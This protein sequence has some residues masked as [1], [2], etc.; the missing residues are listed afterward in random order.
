MIRY[1]K[2]IFAIILSLALVLFIL[3]IL[4]INYFRNDLILLINNRIN[5]NGPFCVYYS[6]IELEPWRF[7]PNITF[8]VSKPNITLNSN[9][10]PVSI[11]RASNLYLNINLLEAIRKNFVVNSLSIADG[12]INAD[13]LLFNLFTNTKNNDAGDLNLYL[14]FKNIAL[15]NVVLSYSVSSN[16]YYKIFISSAQIAGKYYNNTGFF[17]I[18]TVSDSIAYNEKIIKVLTTKVKLR[19]DLSINRN[20]IVL[21]NSEL[22]LYNINFKTDFSYGFLS[23]SLKI[24]LMAQKINLGKQ[25][26]LLHKFTNLKN[27]KGHLSLD[28]LYLTNMSI[29]DY[30]Y[31]QSNFALYNSTFQYNNI[32]HVIINELSGSFYFNSSLKDTKLYINHFKIAHQG[33]YINGAVKIA[34]LNQPLVFLDSKFAIDKRSLT[35]LQKNFSADFSGTL[36]T[37]IKLS[38]LSDFNSAK[39]LQIKSSLL[40]EN[41]TYKNF[42]FLTGFKTQIEIN[43]DACNARFSGLLN[44]SLIKGDIHIPLFMQFLNTRK[45]LFANVSI[46]SDNVDLNYLKNVFGSTSGPKKGLD[47]ELGLNVKCNFNNVEYGNYQFNKVS[48]NLNYGRDVVD[49]PDFN[50]SAF[51]GS[52]KGNASFNNNLIFVSDFDNINIKSLSTFLSNEFKQTDF[53]NFIDGRLAG[54]IRFSGNIDSLLLNKY[55]ETSVV[56]SLKI[57]NGKIS[58]LKQLQK[59]SLLVKLKEL[60]VIEFKTLENTFYLKNNILSIPNMEIRSNLLDL[61]VSGNHLLGG[62]YSYLLNFKLSDL[63]GKKYKNFDRDKNYY[64]DDANRVNLFFKIVGTQKDFS[65]SFDTKSAYNNFK[66]NIIT[67]TRELKNSIVDDIIKPKDPATHSQQNKIDS[68]SNK[69]V[70]SPFKIEWDELDTMKIK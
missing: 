59:L 52:F 65:V 11:V 37:I 61:R 35:I 8:K 67:D 30:N 46:T 43:N 19:G 16:S 13:T 69:N 17:K 49:I 25:Q 12:V 54:N 48:L 39:V 18:Q 2:K 45:D 14:G 57:N 33:S 21:Y 22:S 41:P 32:S 6:K 64:T 70:I 3:F 5:S 60:D 47:I 56:A 55:N 36:K 40:M 1:T 4:F 50:F 62:N 24:S 7:F 44:E 34:N 51:D 38:S 20:S 9:N 31:I 28:F 10:N 53:S 26:S 27:V 23:D 29:P 68:M 63:L 15:K 58:N 66:N 42:D